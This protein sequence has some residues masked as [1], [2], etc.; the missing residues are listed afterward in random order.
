MELSRTDMVPVLWGPQ[1]REKDDVYHVMAQLSTPV[2]KLHLWQDTA[3]WESTS[4]WMQNGKEQ[5]GY[6]A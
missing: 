3:L 1:A 4:C 5:I 6:G 2:P